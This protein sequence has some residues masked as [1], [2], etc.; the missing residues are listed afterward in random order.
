[1]TNVSLFVIVCVF[2]VHVNTFP[3]IN[4]KCLLRLV[5]ALTNMVVCVSVSM[6]FFKITEQGT[7]GCYS[8]EWRM[9]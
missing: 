1:M 5:C 9:T 8:V 7:P 6:S 3:V 2:N 4:C